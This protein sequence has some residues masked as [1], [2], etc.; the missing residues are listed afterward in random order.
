M[1][2][3]GVLCHIGHILSVSSRAK[4]YERKREQMRGKTERWNVVPRCYCTGRRFKAWRSLTLIAPSFSCAIFLK[5]FRGVSSE[6]LPREEVTST[7]L[8][9]T[10]EWKKAVGAGK[11]LGN[12]TYLRELYLLQ[13]QLNQWRSD[14]KTILNMKTITMNRPEKIVNF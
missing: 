14:I 12:F 5:T 4:V 13:V 1:G 9:E 2:V 11:L 7:S 10:E 6:F 8:V 3:D